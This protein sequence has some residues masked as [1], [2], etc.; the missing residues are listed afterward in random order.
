MHRSPVCPEAPVVSVRDFAILAADAGARDGMRRAFHRMLAFFGFEWNDGRVRKAATWRQRFADWARTAGGN[1]L[2]ITRMLTAMTHC[3]LHAE[4]LAFLK[5]LQEEVPQ[6][7][8]GDACKPMSFWMDAVRPRREMR[9]GR[10]GPDPRE[11]SAQQ[12]A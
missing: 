10:D 4:A 11:A 5:T 2:R 3:G 1:D 9:H 6:V 12:R 8:E 7:R